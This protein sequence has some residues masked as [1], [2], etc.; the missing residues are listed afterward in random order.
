MHTRGNLGYGNK[1]GLLSDLPRLSIPGTQ[2]SY[3]LLHCCM[4]TMSIAVTF[5][6]P[7]CKKLWLEVLLW[8]IC[9]GSLKP[10]ITSLQLII[11]S[12]QLPCYSPSCQRVQTPCR[13]GMQPAELGCHRTGHTPR[14]VTVD[15]AL[16]IG[17]EDG[18]RMMLMSLAKAGVLLFAT[19]LRLTAR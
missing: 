6:Q 18:A 9:I 16:P 12:V 2:R 4:K 8:L 10:V 1:H 7:T 3:F 5:Q 11:W 19:G 14:T 17:V 13:A 15:A